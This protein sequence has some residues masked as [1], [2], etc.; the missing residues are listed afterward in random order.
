MRMRRAFPAALAAE[1]NPQL[2]GSHLF[3]GIAQYQ[4]GQMGDAAGSLKAETA[5]T[6]TRADQT[7]A[8]P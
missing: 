2:P 1:L 6:I 5:K 7:G 8:N 3:P 4:A